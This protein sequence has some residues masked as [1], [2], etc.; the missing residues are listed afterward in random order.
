LFSAALADNDR[1]MPSSRLAWPGL[2]LLALS[3]LLP[4]CNGNLIQGHTEEP[5]TPPT[6]VAERKV[7]YAVVG[8]P[9]VIAA[10]VLTVPDAIPNDLQ[11][12]VQRYMEQ[13][14]LRVVT[15]GAQPHE[16]EVHLTLNVAGAAVLMRGTATMDVAAGGQPVARLVTDERIDP[17]GGFGRSLARDLVELLV[18]ADAVASAAD[19]SAASGNVPPPPPADGAK[20]AVAPQ[21]DAPAPGDAAAPGVTTVSLTSPAAAPATSPSPSP[22]PPT[23][24]DGIA[25]ARAHTKQ[26]AAYYDLGRYA[27]ANAEFESAYLIEQDPALLYNMGQCQRKLGK[28]DEAVHFFRTYLRRSPRGPFASAAESRIKEIE[29]EAKAKK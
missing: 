25:A 1:R 6:L 12:W 28:S 29:A 3:G 20:V 8:P 24:P 18:H 5:Q 27:D 21:G 7:R 17:A 13:V 14:G 9:A 2:A 23:G 4:A 26:G 11:D 19:A 15:D 10:P 16:L 22:L